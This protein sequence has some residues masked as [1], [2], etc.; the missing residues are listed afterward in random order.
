MTFSLIVILA[1][2]GWTYTLLSERTY[3]R[4]KIEQ[5]RERHRIHIAV[6]EAEFAKRTR[7]RVTTWVFRRRP[8]AAT[9]PI[10]KPD[11]VDPTPPPPASSASFQGYV[12][13]E[14]DDSDEIGT[15]RFTKPSINKPSLNKPS[16]NTPPRTS[17]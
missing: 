17:P 2:L 6:I 7:E 13:T 12:A 1:I 15:D 5:E 9:E 8:S 14:L 4:R 16:T 3:Y 10:I 11:P